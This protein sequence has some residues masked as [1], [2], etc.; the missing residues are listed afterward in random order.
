MTTEETLAKGNMETLSW[1]AMS[2]TFG[3]ELK[4]KSYLEDH[5]LECFV[6][7]KYD[8][9]TDRRRCKSKQLVPAIHNLL[10]V[11]TTRERIQELKRGLD[12]LQYLTH[13]IDGKN[14]PIIVPD[15]QMQQF[16]AVCN[17]YADSLVYL[18]PDEINLSEGTPVRIIGSAFDGVEG[19]FVKVKKKR[20]KRV[21][22]L[23]R[24][25]A[26]VML[27]EFTDGYLQVLDS[28]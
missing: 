11:H 26:A 3:R 7:M 28:K 23:V 1:F 21:V 10:F 9:V 12:Y 25:I 15:G 4:A 13:S 27:A 22:V 16:I 6:P 19:T 14:V 20:K 17:T 18:A 8:I 2:A 24:G 5:G